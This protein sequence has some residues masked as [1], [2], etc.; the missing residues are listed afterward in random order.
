MRS[1]LLRNF[2]VAFFAVACAHIAAAQTPDDCYQAGLKSD[3]DA[4][5]R[6][7][8]AVLQKADLG[9]RNRSTTL[10]N[11]GLGYLRKGEYDKSIV[12]FSEA[13]IL[14][15]NNQFAFDNRAD[16]WR[17]KGNYERALADYNEALRLDSTLTSSYVSRGITYELQGDLANARRDYQTA[18]DQKGDSALDQWARKRARDRLDK[19]NRR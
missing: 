4:L 9:D 7:C 2:A 10:S 8:S 15:P 19:L 17:E 5:I 18:L 6:I 13:L 3:D 14:N 16:A 11:R 12:D 1:S